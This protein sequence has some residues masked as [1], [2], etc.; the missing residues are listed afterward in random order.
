MVFYP[1]CNRL[2]IAAND[3]SKGNYGL[4]YNKYTPLKNETACKPSNDEGNENG[5]VDYYKKIYAKMKSNK[6]SEMLLKQKDRQID[7]YCASFPDSLYDEIMIRATLTTPLITGIGESHPHEVSMVF[8]HNIGIP[9]IPASGV[10]GIVRFAHTLSLVPGAINSCLVD[11]KGCFNDEAPWTKIP[12]MFGTQER[13]GRVV[14]LDAYP[15]TTPDLHVEI[16]NPHYGPYYSDGKPPADHHNPTA[17]KKF[18]TVKAG[19]TFV[20]RAVAEKK[21]DLPEKVRAA[22]AKALTEEGVG[23]KTAVGYG[24]FVIDKNGYVALLNKRKQRKA[25]DEIL[26]YPWRA[27]LKSIEQVS[28]WGQLKHKL[29]EN[30]D[31]AE[32]RSEMELAK[33]VKSKALEIREKWRSSWEEGRD[34]Q[35]EKW[36]EASGLPWERQIPEEP[37]KGKTAE[38]E[39]I[40]S[41]RD[42]GAYK[43]SGIDY[44]KLPLDALKELL[45]KMGAWGCDANNAKDDKKTAYKQVRNLLKQ[46]EW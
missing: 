35:I 39:T 24:R 8:D 7:D 4:W 3:M 23:A 22:F 16:M 28:D 13:R 27:H 29:L 21:D 46:R 12:L 45:N 15:E 43:V 40:K 25:E 18:L 26:L 30:K 36:L 34:S 31:L 44:S 41:L 20:F 42:W 10:K 11:E 19:S 1:F 33:A 17:I 6:V 5:N 37:P 14:F 38:F 2:R 32:Y 9:Y